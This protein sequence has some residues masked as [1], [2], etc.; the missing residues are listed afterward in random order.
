[1]SAKGHFLQKELRSNVHLVFY[2]LQKLMNSHQ[3][4]LLWKALDGLLTVS[5]TDSAACRKVLKIQLDSLKDAYEEW[6]EY[7]KNPK[8]SLTLM[9]QQAMTRVRRL[10]KDMHEET[11]GV[12]YD[13]MAHTA[14]KLAA[15]VDD[16]I[17]EAM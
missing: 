13:T 15:Q 8:H 3:V 7:E 16:A 10:M 12:V 14:K 9:I 4:G 11:N 17:F 6:L 2:S 1:M 5:L